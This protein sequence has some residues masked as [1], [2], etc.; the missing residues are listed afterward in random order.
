MRNI[1]NI[2]VNRA[3][4]HIID[5]SMEEPIL[6]QRDLYL[7]DETLDFIGKHI[8]KASSD[9]EAKYAK[10]NGSNNIENICRSAIYDEDKF[11]ESSNEIA[12]AFFNLSKSC[13][14]IPSGDLLIVKFESE[15]GKMLAIMKMIYNKTFIHSI[16][17]E[18][19]KMVIDIKTQYIGLPDT[20][21]RLQKCALINFEDDNGEL[22][23]V[24]RPTKQEK[25]AK[26]LN[27]FT[28]EM[29]KCTL[30]DDKRDFTKNFVKSSEKWVRENLK[31]DAGKAEEVR[32]EIGEALR[33]E[34][35]IDIKEIATGILGNDEMAENYIDTLKEEGLKA[36]K[37]E[38][39]KEWVDKKLKRKKLKIDK[40]MEIYINSDAYNDINRFQIKRN[41]DGTIDI[42][43]RQIRNYFEKQ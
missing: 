9:E 6:N 19:E 24:N 36:E 4:I 18:N 38:I 40:D 41:G 33:N 16:D 34:D 42:I 39:D 2:T 20:M 13:G 22:L 11:I 30:I 43:I 29:L 32:R 5:N 37:I 26:N 14:L 3:I 17:Y 28:D 27:T 12:K 25:D 8:A 23:V 7:T 15:Y 35:F 21:Q 10:F 31:E 1:R